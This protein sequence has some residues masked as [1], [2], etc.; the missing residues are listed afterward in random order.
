MNYGYARIGTDDQTTALQLGL[1][2]VYLAK[3]TTE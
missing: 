2:T 1:N 3:R